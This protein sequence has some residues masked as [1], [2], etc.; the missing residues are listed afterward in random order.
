MKKIGMAILCAA[1]AIG[2]M[3]G[4]GKQE[5]TQEALDLSE[6]A[7][8][9]QNDLTFKDSLNQLDDSLMGNFYPSVDLSKVEEYVVYVSGSGSTAEEIALFEVKAPEDA[10]MVKTAIEERITD[11]TVSF[12]DY[13]PEEMVKIENAVVKSGGNYVFAVLCNDYEKAGNLLSEY[14]Q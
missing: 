5:T 7:Q 2:V 1:L 11:Q 13:F 6:I 8:T 9:L 12:Q 14:L 4:C 3:S 10:E